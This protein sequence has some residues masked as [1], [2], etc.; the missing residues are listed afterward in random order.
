MVSLVAHNLSLIRAGKL[1]LDDISL[2]ARGAGSIAII[3]PNGAGK[4]TLLKTFAGLLYPS[5]GAVALGDQ[6]LQHVPADERA[7]T[8]GY[9]PQHFAPHWDIRVRDLLRISV[10][11]VGTAAAAVRVDEVLTTHA[12]G[13]FANRWWSTLSG[14]ESARILLAMVTAIDPPIL[15]ADEPAAALDPLYRLDMIERIAKRGR[16]GIC[17]AVMHDID[18]AFRFFDRIVM[19]KNGQVV[20]DGSAAELFETSHLEETFG[21]RFL[22]SKIDN[23]RFAGIGWPTGSPSA[24][25]VAVVGARSTVGIVKAA[26]L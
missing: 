2:S 4:S 1:L 12:I 13:D 5:A 25:Q 17:I 21:V 9:M 22:R 14:G 15:L 6:A 19:M 26:P 11:R 16:T 20:A 7:R 18:L 24:K 8:I 10:E 23:V 3:G